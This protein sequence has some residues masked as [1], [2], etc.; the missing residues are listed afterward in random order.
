MSNR[1][2]SRFVRWIRAFCWWIAIGGIGVVAILL[3]ASF[4]IHPTF[5]TTIPNAFVFNDVIRTTD[6][7]TTPATI[8]DQKVGLL[9]CR[10]FSFQDGML[11]YTTRDF[12]TVRIYLDDT[13]I[14]IVNVPF[15]HFEFGR[16]FAPDAS[17]SLSYYFSTHNGVRGSNQGSFPSYSIPIWWFAVPFIAALCV[18]L[19]GLWKRAIRNS[20]SFRLRRVRPQIV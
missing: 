15:Q 11:N 4:S 18:L 3:C 19:M 2:Q 5:R 14:R 10:T 13:D 8:T 7:T 12:A 1:T 6:P 17:R 20:D 16:Q 9:A